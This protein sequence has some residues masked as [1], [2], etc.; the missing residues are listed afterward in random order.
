MLRGYI[1]CSAD[2]YVAAPDGGVGFLDPFQDVE[3]G[4]ADFIAEIEGVAM[5]RK[6]FDQIV[7]FDVGWP[8]PD[9]PGHIFTSSPLDTSFPDVARWDGSLASY[10]D[11]MAGRQIWIVG[12]ARLQADIIA[13]GLLDRLDLF[14]IPVLLGAGI[15]L[16]PSDAGPRQ[17]ALAGTEVFDKGIVKLDYRMN[18]GT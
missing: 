3:Y 18:G 5:G 2:G 16:F 9:R 4:Y 10:A 8:Y 1:S 11:A 13:A 7:G 6:T 17:L 14:I 15:P 12:G